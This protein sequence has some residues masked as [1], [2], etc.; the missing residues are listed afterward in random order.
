MSRTDDHHILRQ[1]KS[2]IRSGW[3][4]TLGEDYH[5][6]SPDTIWLGVLDTSALS[7]YRPDLTFAEGFRFRN[8]LRAP[9]RPVD[10]GSAVPNGLYLLP[11]PKDRKRR[12]TIFFMD[13]RGDGARFGTIT[14]SE[15]DIKHHKGAPAIMRVERLERLLGSKSLLIYNRTENPEPLF[16]FLTYEP[17]QSDTYRWQFIDLCVIYATSQMKRSREE[18]ERML[19]RSQK[20]E[21][22][23]REA[24]FDKI[25]ESLKDKAEIYYSLEKLR[26]LLNLL[27]YLK[28]L[29]FVSPVAAVARLHLEGDAKRDWERLVKKEIP[30]LE[31]KLKKTDPTLDLDGTVKK[32]DESLRV[33]RKS[34]PLLGRLSW[35]QVRKQSR[36]QIAQSVS[37]LL[38][39]ELLPDNREAQE[40]LTDDMDKIRTLLTIIPPR[41]MGIPRVTGW[42][43]REYKTQIE[44]DAKYFWAVERLKEQAVAF[45]LILGAAS[46]VFAFFC[47][48]AAAALGILQA[49]ISVDDAIFKDAVSDSDI[50]VDETFITQAEAREAAIFAAID[51][52][53]ALVDIAEVV[54]VV[55]TARQLERTRALVDLP[56]DVDSLADFAGVT[57]AGERARDL[58]R[59]TESASPDALARA[60]ADADDFAGAIA[61]TRTRAIKTRAG[62]I[63]PRGTNRLVGARSAQ[64]VIDEAADGR[65]LLRKEFPESHADDI[66]RRIDD[67]YK[68]HFEEA[69]QRIADA[70]AAGIPNPPGPL[71][72][73]RFARAKWRETLSHFEP[74]GIDPPR[75]LRFYESLSRRH[76]DE[77]LGDTAALRG[78]LTRRARRTSRHAMGGYDQGFLSEFWKAVHR[79]EPNKVLDEILD[80]RFLG[81]IGDLGRR[82]GLTGAPAREFGFWAHGI[83]GVRDWDA[84]SLRALKNLFE[85]VPAHSADTQ[86]MLGRN[87]NALLKVFNRRAFDTPPGL[88]SQL[89]RALDRIKKVDGVFTRSSVFTG[90]SSAEWVRAV[91]KGQV[92]RWSDNMFESL[93]SSHTRG[94]AF[95]AILTSKVLQAAEAAGDGAKV[96]VGRRFWLNAIQDFNVERA[97][98]SGRPMNNILEADIMIE[99]ADGRR[100]LI[101]AKFYQSGFAIDR[102]VVNQAAKMAEGVE[103]G[104]VHSAAFVTSHKVRNL[105]ELKDADGN[106]IGRLRGHADLLETGDGRVRV[107]SKAFENDGLP[108][109]FLPALRAER[110]EGPGGVII[111]R[112]APILTPLP[113]ERLPLPPAAPPLR[114]VVP[115]RERIIDLVPQR[116]QSDVVKAEST[117]LPDASA[118][119]VPISPIHTAPRLVL[120]VARKMPAD[121]S[122]DFAAA[123]LLARIE[124]SSSLGRKFT[125]ALKP[126][127]INLDSSAPNT[128]ANL[129]RARKVCYFRTFGSYDR[130]G[131]PFKSCEASKVQLVG[132]NQSHPLFRFVDENDAFV[133][134]MF[135]NLGTGTDLLHQCVVLDAAG[136]TL[137]TFPRSGYAATRTNALNIIPISTRWPEGD[138]A[139]AFDPGLYRF[140][141]R[142][143]K[144]S[145]VLVFPTTLSL[146]FEASEPPMNP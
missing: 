127:H 56:H 90:L 74:K 129:G 64:D 107:F 140:T 9:D 135:Y 110:V 120:R 73:E 8:M 48:P 17:E 65:N 55:K 50:N 78:A 63:D 109:D 79:G 36:R 32:I 111:E 38:T 53:F 2:R 26:D 5:R 76:I 103:E 66:L 124:K 62:Q 68:A 108:Q 146:F 44:G 98:R 137:R 42:V 51:V 75:R 29:S 85:E 21:R 71:S 54:T 134:V 139:H 91:R 105:R 69:M 20:V 18:M 116:T 14:R 115:A 131:G 119:R 118:T 30:A 99:F 88:R 15:A 128:L 133:A 101:D 35:D 80:R 89:V 96:T 112:P 12:G 144:G 142:F 100:V 60:V 58:A 70:R 122:F 41:V 86:R 25:V 136:R 22:G 92:P 11:T 16:G 1:M 47:P 143:K 31:A 61:T 59:Y 138:Y 83:R 49:V 7:V 125:R 45:P 97:V 81:P 93:T 67:E 52:I 57:A 130:E 27:S 72:Y 132:E 24:D 113:P 123:M 94:F 82:A 6:P 102:R 3:F 4:D 95:E 33:L 23:E 141:L 46:L 43:E 39:E 114:D 121:E 37:K 13:A 40:K 104:I 34:V 106:V 84:D 77:L 117:F 19:T 145:R 126:T 28:Y 87:R 10:F